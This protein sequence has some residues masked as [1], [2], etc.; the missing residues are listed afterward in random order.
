MFPSLQ[1]NQRNDFL[2]N[3]IVEELAFRKLQ[4]DLQLLRECSKPCNYVWIAYT[5]LSLKAVS[6]RL[7]TCYCGTSGYI[8]RPIG[9]EQS[10]RRLQPVHDQD[11]P[12]THQLVGP[13][14]SHADGTLSGSQLQ[15]PI[16][17]V[18]KTAIRPV[19]PLNFAALHPPASKVV[20]KKGGFKLSATS[21]PFVP[22]S[23]QNSNSGVIGGEQTTMNADFMPVEIEQFASDEAGE[24]GREGMMLGSVRECE[25]HNAGIRTLFNLCKGG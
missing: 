20:P 16:K 11:A 4:L 19:I 2:Q 10:F 7:Q 8:P 5:I 6:N 18:S 23:G 13:T 25:Q 9:Y 3:E 21:A 12:C 14:E 15:L 17:P 24:G 22:S 1:R